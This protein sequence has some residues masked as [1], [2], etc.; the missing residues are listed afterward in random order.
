MNSPTPPPGD[1]P[2][3]VVDS[4]LLQR[5][6]FAAAYSVL[7][8]GIEERAFPGAAFGV[9]FHGQVVALDGVGH[10]TYEP[11]SPTAAPTTISPASPK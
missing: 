9:Y 8:R 5:D 4:T 3:S 11:D 2:A 7:R 1:L 10:F 6:H